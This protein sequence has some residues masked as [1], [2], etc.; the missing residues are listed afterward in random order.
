[1]ARADLRTGRMAIATTTTT[2]RGYIARAAI[3]SS[4]SMRAFPAWRR[5]GHRRPAVF[6]GL[7]PDVAVE[8]NLTDWPCDR[9]SGQPCLS[10]ILPSW[11][12]AGNHCT[13][14]ARATDPGLLSRRPLSGA[15]PD[16]PGSSLERLE[17]STRGRRWS[18]SAFDGFWNE[19]GASCFARSGQGAPC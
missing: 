12:A 3:A 18:E 13:T 10:L 19:F 8:I 5:A 7:W 15:I 1:M 9:S 2:P 4:S 17:T 6:G 11:R 14:R 16:L